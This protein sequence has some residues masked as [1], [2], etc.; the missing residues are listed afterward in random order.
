MP[1]RSFENW[2]KR[3]V[4]LKLFVA[5][6]HFKMKLYINF[7]GNLVTDAVYRFSLC[8][9]Y[10]VLIIIVIILNFQC[11]KTNTRYQIVSRQNMH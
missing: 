9:M 10:A 7:K 5:I 8:N 4:L 6:M 2:T 3:T 1:K 11:N